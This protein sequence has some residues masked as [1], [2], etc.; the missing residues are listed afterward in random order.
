MSFSSASSV[1]AAGF[2]LAARG[3][4]GV[5]GLA[6]AALAVVDRLVAG[7]VVG[8]LPAGGR[9]VEARTMTSPHAGFGMRCILTLN[10]GIGWDAV[11]GG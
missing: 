9:V 5:A 4:F 3:G 10:I 7:R 1:R 11:N 6:E 8:F 2:A